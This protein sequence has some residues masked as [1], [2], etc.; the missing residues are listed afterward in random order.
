[1][2]SLDSDFSNA[3]ILEPQLPDYENVSLEPLNRKF[4]WSLFF[5]NAIFFILIIIVMSVLQI[6]V[7]YFPKPLFFTIIGGFSL[8][9]LT[10]LF[11]LFKTF[12]SRGYAIREH[13]LIYK[14][15]VFQEVTTIVPIQNIQHLVFERTVLDKQW[16]LARLLCFT[17]GGNS[18][19]LILRGIEYEKLQ[20]IQAFIQSSVESNS[21]KNQ[22]HLDFSNEE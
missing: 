18:A 13:D 20:R 3:Q 8:F 1:M 5:S 12:Q 19:D 2:D 15:G 17:S 14:S 6:W 22:D 21:T 10:R 11:F 4:L 7:V 9:F 16:G